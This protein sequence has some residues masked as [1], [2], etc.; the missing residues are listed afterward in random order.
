M[1]AAVLITAIKKVHHITTCF[2]FRPFDRDVELEVLT[3]VLKKL[4]FWDMLDMLP[5][6]VIYILTD[7][8]EMLFS[9]LSGQFKIVTVLYICVQFVQTVLYEHWFLYV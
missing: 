7:I 6:S 4:V 1:T 2:I 8:L 5:R 9:P 3:A